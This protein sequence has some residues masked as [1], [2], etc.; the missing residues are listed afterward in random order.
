MVFIMLSGKEYSIV[1]QNVCGFFLVFLIVQSFS[2]V[3]LQPHGRQ[4]ARLP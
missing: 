4:H 1:S 2:R 3:S